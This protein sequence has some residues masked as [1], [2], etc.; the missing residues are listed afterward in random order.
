MK[1]YSGITMREKDLIR[2]TINFF[3]V[4]FP[5]KD[6]AFEMKCGYFWEWVGRLK[7]EDPI[8]YMDKESAE[9]WDLVKELPRQ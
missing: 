9:A 6:I 8:V 1:I 3:K 4:R 5:E 7:A 2:V